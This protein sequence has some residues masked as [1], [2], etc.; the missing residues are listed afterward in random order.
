MSELDKWAKRK[1]YPVTLHDGAVV[2]VSK[3]SLGE[4]R[5]QAKL[6][7]NDK[8]V[9]ILASS[10]VDADGNKVLP[11]LKT[12]TGTRE[13]LAEY[14]ERTAEELY[15]FGGDNIAEAMKAITRIT[16]PPAEDTLVKN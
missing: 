4:L 10:L 16:T 11:R 13:P 2:H 3:M 8:T 12:E 7:P 6:D 1:C 14:V 5:E 9:F 15:E